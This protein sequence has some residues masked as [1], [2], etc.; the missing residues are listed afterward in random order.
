MSRDLPK[1]VRVHLE[2]VVGIFGGNGSASLSLL[3]D[4]L[5]DLT[6]PYKRATISSFA[7]ILF[8]HFRDMRERDAHRG[9]LSHMM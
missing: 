4:L 9:C 7:A 3:L 6:P 1:D 2:K 5:L 8:F